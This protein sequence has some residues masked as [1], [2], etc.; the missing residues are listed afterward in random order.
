MKQWCLHHREIVEWVIVIAVVGSVVA[1]AHWAG[2]PLL[3]L[4]YLAP[5]WRDT[6]GTAP[7][8]AL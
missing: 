8:S 4:H 1:V 2:S 5:V 6:P 7:A 3:V